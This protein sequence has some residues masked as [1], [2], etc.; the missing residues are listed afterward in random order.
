MPRK[1]FTIAPDAA[2]RQIDCE[3]YSLNGGSPRCAALNHPWCLA[4][5]EAP[6][7]CAF[8]SPKQ[9]EPTRKKRRHADGQTD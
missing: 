4:P 3:N 1:K 5:G 7:T 9:Q 6:E 8:R 2:R